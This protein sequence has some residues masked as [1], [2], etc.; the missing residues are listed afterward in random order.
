MRGGIFLRYVGSSIDLAERPFLAPA[1]ALP[2][3]SE[4]RLR[5][6]MF[7]RRVPGSSIGLCVCPATCLI[8]YFEVELLKP[9]APEG[10]SRRNIIAPRVARVVG[11]RRAQRAGAT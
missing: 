3:S 6:T 8:V 11:Y 9:G 4:Y 1:V 2:I 7:F 5:F 10:K